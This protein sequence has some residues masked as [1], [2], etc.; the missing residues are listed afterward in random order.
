MRTH[1]LPIVVAAIALVISARLEVQGQEAYT[2]RPLVEIL[3]R[4]RPAGA[5]DHEG[6]TEKTSE[7]LQQ[8]RDNIN[9]HQMD[10]AR[11]RAEG[12]TEA[13]IRRALAPRLMPSATGSIAGTILESDGV[14]PVSGFMAVSAYDRFGRYS[15]Y[16]YALY[17]DGV[18]TIENLATG[19]YY[20]QLNASG[21]SDAIS[22]YYDDVIDWRQATLVHVIDGQQTTGIDFV[23]RSAGTST[24]TGGSTT[25][26]CRQSGRMVD[27]MI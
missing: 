2:V 9:R 23:I 17:S 27:G 26:Y 10:A 12:K 19:D 16:G 4:H 8:V 18:Y 21:V 15:G 25:R 14:T 11:L 3:S 20:V 22:V 13:D 7:A 6:R 1:G 24:R 5:A